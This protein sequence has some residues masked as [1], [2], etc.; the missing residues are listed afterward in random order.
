MH[1][2]NGGVQCNLHLTVASL[3]FDDT[4]END[5]ITVTRKG[6]AYTKRTNA[7]DQI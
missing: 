4:R 3:A 6:N 1:L 7:C 2:V 5:E